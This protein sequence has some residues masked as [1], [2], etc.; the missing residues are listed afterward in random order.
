MPS[1]LG[2]PVCKVCKH[3]HPFGTPHIGLAPSRSADKKAAAAV[4][5]KQLVKVDALKKREPAR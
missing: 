2:P 3:P 4:L 5:H 1:H